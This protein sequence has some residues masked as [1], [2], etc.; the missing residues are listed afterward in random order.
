MT[1]RLLTTLKL[2]NISLFLFLSTLGWYRYGQ[3]LVDL[4]REIYL[5][6]RVSE[7]ARPYL[8]F[9]HPH[10]SFSSLWDGLWFY[11]LGAHS[12]SLRGINTTLAALF[13]VL[14]FNLLRTAWGQI[15]AAAATL[16]V[17]LSFIFGCFE[18]STIFNFIAPYNQ[19]SLHS[20]VLAVC[21]MAALITYLRKPRSRLL[22][23]AG[24]TCG[25]IHFTR[26]DTAL[27][28]FVTLSIGLMLVFINEKRR[29]ARWVLLGIFSLGAAIPIVIFATYFALT[30][31]VEVF[32]RA[33][34]GPWAILS[35]STLTTSRQ[36][37]AT[38]LDDPIRNLK[39]MAACL[40]FVG[41]CIGS[42][43]ALGKAAHAAKLSQQ[44]QRLLYLYSGI[45]PLVAVALST[46]DDQSAVV[47]VASDAAR[48]RSS[49][50]MAIAH[51]ISAAGQ[52]PHF[53]PSSFRTSTAQ[54]LWLSD[55]TPYA[56]QYESF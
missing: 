5:A 45:I 8:D 29:R 4:P 42:L 22:L 31:P 43:W 52:K 28:L 40:G 50:G 49:L 32:G 35:K 9:E 14:L 1:R 55:V 39:F 33:M 56:A 12:D 44:Q 13:T 38:G 24:A 53:A 41:L 21:G 25:A 16:L 20:L 30:L 27:A 26:A 34:W 7:G 19:S 36:L 10:G 18:G 48:S 54:H 47:P 46:K 17:Q 23:A 37:W 15:P 2:A 6:W 11:V 51:F 3:I